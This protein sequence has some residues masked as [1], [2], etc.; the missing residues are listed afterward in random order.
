MSEI[1]HEKTNSKKHVG[2]MLKKVA[3]P[4][5]SY[6]NSNAKLS[7]ANSKMARMMAIRSGKPRTFVGGH[8]LVLDRKQQNRLVCTIAHGV[9]FLW[10]K[11]VTSTHF[12][13]QI[14]KFTTSCHDCQN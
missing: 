12:Y 7:Y 8:C 9:Q 13:G 3:S 14:A 10:S 11:A 2:F 6:A 1:F 5:A 4:Y